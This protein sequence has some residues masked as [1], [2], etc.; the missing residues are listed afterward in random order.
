MGIHDLGGLVMR[1]GAAFKG[2]IVSLALASSGLA[3]AK[4]AQTTFIVDPQGALPAGTITAQKNQ[5]ILTLIGRA[6]RA[7]QLQDDISPE[8]SASAEVNS[9]YPL[10]AG[11]I[12]LGSEERPGTFCAPISPHGLGETGPCLFDEDGDGKFEKISLAS[13]DSRGGEIIL[14]TI[15]SKM[16]PAQLKRYRPLGV[17]VAYVP[18]SYERSQ[19]AVV[20]LAWESNYKPTK[21]DSPVKVIFWLDG[22]AKFT[23]TGV[24]SQPV[25]VTFTGKPV[26][27]KVEGVSIRLQGIGPD[28]SIRCEVLGIDPHRAVPMSSRGAPQI[29]FI[30]L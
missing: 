25:Q 19:S 29:W 8:D 1:A 10:K 12:L 26:E 5:D 30:W 22:S 18:A 15:K 7:V 16:M 27:L 21:P 13:F 2:W 11:Q 9:A 20:R 3:C 6:S 28:G 17:P 24:S 14:I 4:N 23:A